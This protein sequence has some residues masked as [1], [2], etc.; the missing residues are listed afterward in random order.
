MLR[1]VVLLALL[2]VV[3]AGCFGGGKAASQ[4]AGEQDP[5]Q[6]ARL[7]RPLHFPRVAGARCPT[8]RGRYVATPTASGIALGSGPVRVFINNPGDLRHGMAHLG[9]T[10]FPGWLAL[11][12]HFFSVPAYQGPFLVR[13]KSLDRSGPIALGATPTQAGPLLMPP[14]PAAN[15]AAGWREFPYS[16]FVKAPGCYA[17]QV[18]GL[19]FSK[20][21]VVRMLPKLDG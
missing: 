2:S 14:G 12:T 8:S 3:L 21:I 18:D 20:T 5:P 11:K 1:S 4:A 17:W 7:M 16:T 10:E 19:T 9:S 6:S 13:A 15:G